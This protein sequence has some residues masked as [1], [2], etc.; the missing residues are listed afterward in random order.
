M[1]NSIVRICGDEANYTNFASREELFVNNCGLQRMD[2]PYGVIRERGRVDWH[3]I[4]MTQGRGTAEID[5]KVHLLHENDMLLY[6]PDQPQRYFFLEGYAESFYLHF[7]GTRCAELLDKC[8]LASGVYSVQRGSELRLIFQR[9]LRAYR[10]EGEWASI[11]RI[12]CLMELLSMLGEDVHSAN[13]HINPAGGLMEY[14]HAHCAEALDLDAFAAQNGIG[15]H[16]LTQIFREQ[17]GLTPHRYKLQLQL[18]DAKHLLAH[19]DQSVSEIAQ[20]IGIADPLYFSRVFKKNVGASPREYRKAWKE[21]E[22][23]AEA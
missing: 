11:A 13:D 15:A 10:A 3:I 1:D 12:G 17:T 14:I 8:R 6:A 4:L 23:R 21:L 2:R 9:L 16:R 20:H 7:S 22:Q 18:V 5:G 19:T